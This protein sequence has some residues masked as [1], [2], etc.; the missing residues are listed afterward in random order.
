[1]VEYLCKTE[2]LKL[3]QTQASKFKTVC[4]YYCP[5]SECVTE[6]Q[7]TVGLTRLCKVLLS[8]LYNFVIYIQS[9]DR[10]ALQGIILKKYV[11]LIQ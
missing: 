10:T 7:K 6:A 8:K 5:C 11:L 9:S 1:M 4:H 3:L 2:S